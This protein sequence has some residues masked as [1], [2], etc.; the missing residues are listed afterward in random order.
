MYL[1]FMFLAG[2]A[3]AVAKDIIQDNSLILPKKDGGKLV[4][5]FLGGT[6]TGGIAGALIDGSATTAFMAGYAG[7]SIIEGLIKNGSAQFGQGTE[8]IE[9]KIRRIAKEESV[10]PDLA[11]KVATC[12]SKLN[13]TARNYNSADSVDRGL[14]Q[15][16]SKWHPEVTDAQADD[17]EYATRFFCKAFK[18]GNLSWWKATQSC[19]EK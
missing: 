1:I 17:P 13:P 6:I 8:T 7:T 10:D 5:G 3:G 18:E 9:Q 12:E 14:F 19:W 4:L 11:V 2:A 15:I 16:N